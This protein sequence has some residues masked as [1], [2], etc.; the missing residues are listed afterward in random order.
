MK[1]PMEKKKTTSEKEHLE[2]KLKGNG[3]KLCGL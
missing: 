3:I 1:G 2:K